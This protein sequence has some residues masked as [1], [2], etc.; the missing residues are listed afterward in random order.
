MYDQKWNDG[1]LWPGSGLKSCEVLPEQAYGLPEFI[2]VMDERPLKKVLEKFGFE[3]VES[4]FISMKRFG[5]EPD[6]NGQESYGIIA[7]KH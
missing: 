1:N 4:N 7:K 6:R 5:S 2:H 3:I